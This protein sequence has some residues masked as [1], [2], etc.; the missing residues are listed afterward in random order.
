MAGLLDR[1]LNGT[2]TDPLNQAGGLEGYLNQFNVN[3]R[4]MPWM[5]AGNQ[6]NVQSG[7]TGGGGLL[8][9]TN[10]YEM[11]TP[12]PTAAPQAAQAS[13]TPYKIKETDG[14]VR[15]AINPFTEL[16]GQQR[17]FMDNYW[18]GMSSPVGKGNNTGAIYTYEVPEHL[19]NQAATS[20]K[21]ATEVGYLN[22]EL[23]RLL[24]YGGK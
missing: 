12:A 3:Q 20:P 5:Q 10:P 2:G 11:A 13:N 17:A 19:F 1:F 18:N 23:M 9:G 4:Y 14:R 22:N 8:N 15:I 7:A 16:D 6:F 21:N 24:G